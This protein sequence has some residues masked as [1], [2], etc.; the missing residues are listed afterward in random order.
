MNILQI[1]SFRQYRGA[2]LSA[3]NLSKQ[4][5]EEGHRLFWVGLFTHNETELILPDA[6]NAD[7]PGK[8]TY[9]NFEKVKALK[10]FIIQ[11][12]IDVIQA[13]GAETLKYAVAAT[14]FTKAPP[15]VY[16]NISQVSF[17][18]KGSFLKK[19]LSAF[20]FRKASA[21]VSVGKVSR[22]DVVNTFPFV[23][24]K[25]SVIY[26]G[27]PIRVVWKEN[28]GEEVR[29]VFSLSPSARILLWVG[30]LSPE[31]NP[32]FMIDVMK[33]V[34]ESVPDA[35]L[36]MAGKGPL[37]NQLQKQIAAARMHKTVLLIGYK[38]NL[39]EIYAGAELFLLASETE[40]I[41]GV[42]L[43]A[44]IQST[45]SVAVNVGGV[46]E[47]VQQ[48]ETGMLITQHD[49]NQFAQAVV[50]LLENKEEL[51]RLGKNAAAFVTDQFNEKKNALKFL[52]LYSKLKAG[53]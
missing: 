5:Q 44:A 39:E 8:K 18:M 13:N 37:E 35:V 41:P 32:F 30:A 31:K 20:L 42:I 21:V 24:P 29:A 33:K 48:A 7:M 4:L 19:M 47:V 6:V 22:D 53:L 50:H 17:W 3:W 27:V 25:A 38:S 40:G 26:R 51:V 1:V 14:M 11:H 43:E 9:L 34:T 23:A 52:E 15:I 16:R 45:P 46:A 2:E 49:A 10:R 28:A 36:L 12:K